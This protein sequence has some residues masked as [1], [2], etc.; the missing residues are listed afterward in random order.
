MFFYEIHQFRTRTISIGVE[1]SFHCLLYDVG[2]D[3]TPSLPWKDEEF[4]VTFLIFYTF[5]EGGGRYN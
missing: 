1:V 2:L 4:L 3:M 5:L